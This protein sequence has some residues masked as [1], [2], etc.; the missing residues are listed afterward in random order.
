M[1]V[2]LPELRRSAGLASAAGQAK[3]V[4]GRTKEEMLA[5]SIPLVQTIAAGVVS[6]IKLPP[7]F[8][9]EDLVGFGMEGLVKAFDGFDKSHGVLFRTYASYR[10]RGEMLDR[11]REEWRYRNF[12]MPRVQR[13]IVEVA[14]ESLME[15]EEGKPAKVQDVVAN[16]AIVYL[17]SID[18]LEINASGKGSF[19][20]A[21][22]LLE[23]MEYSRER[24][25]L[26][27][28]IERSL[29]DLERQVV[30][31]FYVKEMSQKDIASFLGLSR[32]KV[33]RL[34]SRT[35]VKLRNY[36]KTALI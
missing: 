19:D 26:R 24:K 1:E 29:D 21:E 32:S 18:G 14:K 20:P 33:N 12:V 10:I 17:L 3:R 9:F 6:S 31:L 25:V 30:E 16:S 28:A 8:S 34:H 13:K 7:T 4:E 2:V 11:I 15:D 22:E 27:E 35:V 36:L 5:G 23:E